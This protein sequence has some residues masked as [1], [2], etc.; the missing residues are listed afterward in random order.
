MLSCVG[1]VLSLSCSN[2][3]KD[4]FQ[5][6]PLPTLTDQATITQMSQR[7]T[8]YWIQRKYDKVFTLLAPRSIWANPTHRLRWKQYLARERDVHNE[9]P[10]SG[11]P[12][13]LVFVP[14][15]L[16]V[17]GKILILCRS[18]TPAPNQNDRIKLFGMDKFAGN[19]AL[20]QFSLA[21]RKYYQAWVR[22]DKGWRC[23]NLPVDIDENNMESIAA[24]KQFATTDFRLE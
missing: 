18:Y 12:Q 15:T 20:L 4:T 24:W 10:D 13:N 2:I 11:S 14:T 17:Y 3:R 22:S 21:N 5:F 6:I 8:Q 19:V 9:I 7:Y 23:F 16:D 1:I